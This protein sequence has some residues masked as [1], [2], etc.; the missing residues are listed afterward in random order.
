MKY[1][2]RK[3]IDSEIILHVDL[4]GRALRFE[5][6]ESFAFALSAEATVASSDIAAMF[7]TSI[8][9]LCTE[10]RRLRA[11]RT[12]LWGTGNKPPSA[13]ELLHIQRNS[14]GL[15]S[16]WDKTVWRQ[17]FSTLARLTATESP[18]YDVAVNHYQRFLCA[19]EAAL[20]SSLA[21]REI[22]E[23]LHARL[24]TS[25]I[26]TWA[27]SLT[28]TWQRLRPR[29]ILSLPRAQEF[30][31]P[32]RL[33]DQAF[34]LAYYG[35][36]RWIEPHGRYHKLRRG[37]HILGRD[38]SDGIKLSARYRRVSRRH[39]LVEVTPTGIIS[40]RD[41]SRHGTSVPKSLAVHL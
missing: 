30:I 20:H 22:P 35:A 13:T 33:A 1:K 36:W 15:G 40:L 26:E 37:R 12:R 14:N 2:A 41:L 27:E 17:V 16:A 4:G 18:Y 11:L 9:Q 10:L 3:N 19:W 29:Q 7:S 23:K 31:T 21:R 32:I 6:P 8:R 5:S 28:P 34:V 24:E 39:L 38:A 25:D